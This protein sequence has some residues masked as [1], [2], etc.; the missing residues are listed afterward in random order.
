MIRLSL[1]MRLLAIVLSIVQASLALSLSGACSNEDIQECGGCKNFGCVAH[2][3]NYIKTIPGVL[4]VEECQD[5]CKNESVCTY[6]TYFGKDAFPLKN[7]CYL[8][9]SCEMQNDCSDCVTEAVDCLCSTSIIGTI[10]GTN[11]LKDL[12]DV[13]SERDCRQACVKTDNCRF[14][15]YLSDQ[16]QCILLS[17]LIEP[18]NKCEYCKTGPVDCSGTSSTTTQTSSSTTTPNTTTK[19]T[20]KPFTTTS[21]TPTSAPTTTPTTTAKTTP[22]PSTTTSLT[23]M[24]TTPQTTTTAYNPCKIVLPSGE[25]TTHHKFEVS[26][27]VVNITFQGQRGCYF[28]AIAVGGGGHGY[29]CGGGSGNIYNDRLCFGFDPSTSVWVSAGGPSQNSR[30]SINGTNYWAWAGHDAHAQSGFYYGG[31]GY[32]GGGGYELETAKPCE[33]NYNSGGRNGSN[34]EGTWTPVNETDH[35]L[36][37]CGLGSKYDISS[38]RYHMDMFELSPGQ[39]GVELSEQDKHFCEVYGG[40][41]GG[42]LVDGKG[43][44]RR[45]GH[46][47][48]G[49][50]AGGGGDGIVGLPGV[51]LI[52]TVYGPC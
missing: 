16:L 10:D 25:V 26:D 45:N 13:N 51:V 19:T 40:G 42:V 32:S 8:Y 37:A 11:F 9:S 44:T 28:S 5:Q 35:I 7:F 24:T 31:S 41:G 38:D 30:I 20:P 49:Y 39:G 50:G 18:L 3:D 14:Y 36:G 48:S 52:E 15:T 17:D 33:G 23:P 27:G 1:I 34:G 6:L 21:T 43:P 47:G 12:V 22:K 46:Q 2:N 29:Y 4:T